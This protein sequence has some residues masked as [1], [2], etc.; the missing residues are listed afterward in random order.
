M[1]LADLRPDLPDDFI[2]IVERACEPDP[3]RRYSTIAAVKE[4]LSRTLGWDTWT[5][6]HPVTTS[7]TGEM[8]R[9]CRGHPAGAADSCPCRR[10]L[11]S[12]VPTVSSPSPLPPWP[13]AASV[14]W[15]LLPRGPGLRGP[16]TSFA[17]IVPGTG[18]THRDERRCAAG[19]RQ[20]RGRR[21]GAHAAGDRAARPGPQLVTA[22]PRDRA[23]RGRADARPARRSHHARR[24]RGRVPRG[25]RLAARHGHAGAAH[26][27]ARG[28][29]RCRRSRKR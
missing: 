8:C 11:D 14:A 9:Q 15:S 20:R 3:D 4:A 24:R 25:G 18:T 7:G 28:R 1:P 21:S 13:S 12:R 29:H 10:H 16:S 2:R 6:K 23:R 5:R 27:G 19:H 26:R 17:T 22:V